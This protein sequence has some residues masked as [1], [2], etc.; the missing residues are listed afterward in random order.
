MRG[1]LIAAALTVFLLPGCSM[2]LQ[3]APSEREFRKLH[4]HPFVADP[5]RAEAILSG[6][7]QISICSR[8]AEVRRLMGD[9]DFGVVTD[10]SNGNHTAARWTYLLD[11][12]PA[13]GGPRYA[14]DVTVNA[15]RDVISIFAYSG[16]E[17]NFSLVNDGPG[18]YHR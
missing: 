15:S 14:V 8:T 10:D 5:A 18:C 6:A 12:K 13:A 16:S 4:A 17:T 2:R 9:P 7:R 3:G 1:L 11:E